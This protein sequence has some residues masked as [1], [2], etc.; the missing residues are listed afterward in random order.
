M[1]LILR[2]YIA[3]SPRNNSFINTKRSLIPIALRKSF[4][5]ESFIV[6]NF[7]FPPSTCRSAILSSLS[8]DSFFSFGICAN[9][10][11]AS[12]AVSKCMLNIRNILTFTVA[13]YTSA[14]QVFE[15]I[16]SF[17]KFLWLAA[18]IYLLSFLP[19]QLGLTLLFIIS[20]VWNSNIPL[21]NKSMGILPPPLLYLRP[22]LLALKAINSFCNN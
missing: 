16:Y 3:S 22:F 4:T 14:M 11:G 15:D 1:V 2:S 12:I 21:K 6:C 17:G 7:C 9:K 18:I 19:Q 10:V 8:Y 13:A 5:G 20:I